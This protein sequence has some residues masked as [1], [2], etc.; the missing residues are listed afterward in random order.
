MFC[1][2]LNAQIYISPPSFL[3]C[4]VLEIWHPMLKFVRK[5]KSIKLQVGGNSKFFYFSIFFGIF[6]LVFFPNFISKFLF[7]FFLLKKNQFFC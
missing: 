1:Y 2:S 7:Y 6:F 5:L 3:F 4:N